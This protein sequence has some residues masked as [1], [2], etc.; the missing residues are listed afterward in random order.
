MFQAVQLQEVKGAVI[1]VLYTQR[2]QVPQDVTRPQG[3]RLG[4][5]HDPGT[6]SIPKDIPK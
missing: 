4:G 6:L 5:G 2:I 1:A 3:S